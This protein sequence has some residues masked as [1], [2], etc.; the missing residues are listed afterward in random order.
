MQKT[1][2]HETPRSIAKKLDVPE[3]DIVFLNRRIF[4][5]APP[6]PLAPPFTAFPRPFPCLSL[7]FPC[8]SLRFHCIMQLYSI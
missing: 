8:L 1:T 7:T 3:F 2:Y 6:P 4:P 5:G